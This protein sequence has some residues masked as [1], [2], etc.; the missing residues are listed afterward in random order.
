MSRL[1]DAH[2]SVPAGSSPDNEYDEP[3][4]EDLDYD[5]DA[6]GDAADSEDE[7]DGKDGRTIANVRG[8][9]LRKLDK[10][11]QVVLDEIRALREENARLKDQYGVPTPAAR[12]SEPKTLDDLSIQ[13]LEQMRLNV[14]DEQKAAFEEYYIQRKV[15]A[16]VDEK[17]SGFEQQTTF[18][19]QEQ[20]YNAQAFE[21][22]PQLHDRNSDFYRVTDRIMREMGNGADANPRAVLDAA[23]EAGFEL[24]IGPA[25]GIRRSPRDPGGV[26]PGRTSRGTKR[27]D[28]APEL[29]NG[30]T[31]RLAEAMPGKKFSKEQ[32]K[33]IAERTKEYQ[34]TINTRVRG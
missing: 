13:E 9:L 4:N 15:A 21:R 17:L 26:V 27:Q 8:E 12:T 29:D 18:R 16:T 24:G 11:Q 32:L 19:T 33:R 7:P 10:S 14:P 20:K 3:V 1:D 2:R 23:N 30:V 22:W 5:A 34:D 28:E 6:A 25:S 31:S